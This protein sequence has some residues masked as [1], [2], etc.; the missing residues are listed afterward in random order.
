MKFRHGYRKAAEVNRTL[1]AKTGIDSWS[2]AVPEWQKR[3]QVVDYPSGGI[4]ADNLENR[5]VS[6]CSVPRWFAKKICGLI[7]VTHKEGTLMMNAFIERQLGSTE[8]KCLVQ[9][10]SS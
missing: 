4:A 6:A 1:Y 10:H 8:V 3:K 7:L 9:G 5:L 2:I